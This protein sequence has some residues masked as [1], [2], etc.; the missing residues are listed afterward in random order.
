MRLGDIILVAFVASSQLLMVF[1]IAAWITG[2]PPGR[3]RVVSGPHG[4]LARGIERDG[5]KL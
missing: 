2:W 3:K 5:R 4:P 1:A